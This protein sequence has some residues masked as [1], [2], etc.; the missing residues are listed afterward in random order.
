VPPPRRSAADTR[1][2]VL[3]V[4]RELFYWRGIHAVGV[5]T[6]AHQAGV[7]TTTL[8]RLFGS[9]DGLIAAYVA[10]E[11]DGHRAWFETS[12]GPADQPPADRL[13][14]LFHALTRLVDPHNCRGC[15]FQ[16]ALAET[17]A[18][19][20]P[21]HAEAVAVKHWIRDRFGD[22]AT[23]HLGARRNSRAARELADG[24]MLVFEGAFATAQSLGA[25]GPPKSL[26]GVVR[27]LLA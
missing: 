5:D 13:V 23:A 16:M 15:P 3:A 11:A 7:A 2:H 12:L 27:A 22:L 10:R 19:G 25:D 8:Y 24:L 1:E 26:V 17:P 18:P 14:A 21:A 4:T 9:K 20:H 6:I